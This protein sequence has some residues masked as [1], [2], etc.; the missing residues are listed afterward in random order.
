[1]TS[2]ARFEAIAPVINVTVVEEEE[3]FGQVMRQVLRSHRTVG[4]V[5]CLFDIVNHGIDQMKDLVVRISDNFLSLDPAM[6]SARL[7]RQL[8]GLYM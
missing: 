7:E 3:E 2:R 4:T 5:Y 8:I 6:F 1:M